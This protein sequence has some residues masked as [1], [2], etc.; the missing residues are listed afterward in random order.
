MH[1]LR[2]RVESH[3]QVEPKTFVSQSIL[4]ST[5]V[6]N[7]GRF[8]KLT[9]SNGVSFALMAYGCPSES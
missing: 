8:V 7:Q 5:R 6:L 4:R 2:F 9:D 1:A 3:L